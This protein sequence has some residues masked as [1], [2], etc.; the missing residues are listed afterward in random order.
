MCRDEDHLYNIHNMSVF[1][2]MAFRYLTGCRLVFVKKP[3]KDK[4]FDKIL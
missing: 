4:S 3:M 2:F 1:H